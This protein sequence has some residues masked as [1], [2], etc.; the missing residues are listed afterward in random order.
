[1]SV[2]VQRPCR[3]NTRATHT[4][5]KK[6]I[7]EVESVPPEMIH[8]TRKQGIQYKQQTAYKTLPGMPK[9]CTDEIAG[10]R[11]G[12]THSL[13]VDISSPVHIQLPKNTFYNI[14]TKQYNGPKVGSMG[15]GGLEGYITLEVKQHTHTQHSIH[16]RG[17]GE[18]ARPKIVERE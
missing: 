10:R 4:K 15:V 5:K 6:A 14:L 17:S 11:F 1:M 8:R 16:S 2:K 18:S 12:H 7:I 9:T 3:W 13:S